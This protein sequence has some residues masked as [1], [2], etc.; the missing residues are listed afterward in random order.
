L[1]ALNGAGGSG[2]CVGLGTA[3]G[4]LAEEPVFRM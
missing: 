2:R 1:D 4:D 3:R